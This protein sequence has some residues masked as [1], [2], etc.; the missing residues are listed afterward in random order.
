MKRGSIR[1]AASTQVNQS[2]NTTTF[3]VSKYQQGV[4]LVF[5]LH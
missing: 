3:P 1:Q 4:A 2:T 5:R